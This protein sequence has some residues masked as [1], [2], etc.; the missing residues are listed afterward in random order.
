MESRK[1]R[2]K[3]NLREIDVLI[4]RPIRWAIVILTA[5]VVRACHSTI[6]NL[7]SRYQWWIN[8]Y[9]A[10]KF[11]KINSCQE[12]WTMLGSKEYWSAKYQRTV[13]GLVFRV[14]STQ[15]KSFSFRKNK[16]F[17]FF[18]FFFVFFL[19]F[20]ANFSIL[21]SYYPFDFSAIRYKTS[22]SNVFSGE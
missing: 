5:M 10:D 2:E 4:K 22:Q 14:S 12:Y 19:R 8:G 16:K 18:L 6:F 11:S 13:F 3:E 20:K 15:R 7:C 9:T 21:H 1:E 17:F